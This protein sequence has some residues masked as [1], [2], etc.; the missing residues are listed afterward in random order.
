MDPLITQLNHLEI[1]GRIDESSPDR[2]TTAQVVDEDAVSPSTILEASRRPGKE[3]I[4]MDD[5]VEGRS[6]TPLDQIENGSGFVEGPVAE[7]ELATVVLQGRAGSWCRRRL[8]EGADLGGGVREVALGAVRLG[9][10][11]RSEA[12]AS[13]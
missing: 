8:G 1:I 2:E 5:G 4:G 12:T 9:L 3:P 7:R 13:C 11:L 6:G 10:Q